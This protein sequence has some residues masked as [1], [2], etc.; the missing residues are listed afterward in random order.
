MPGRHHSVHRAGSLLGLWA[1]LLPIGLGVGVLTFAGTWFPGRPLE[2]ASMGVLFIGQGLVLAA[3]LLPRW[4][5]LIPTD[6][7]ERLVI[8]V[9][10][11]PFGTQRTWLVGEAR[12]VALVWAADC[13]PLLND[14]ISH[15]SVELRPR[16]GKACVIA[17]WPA[18]FMPHDRPP[19]ALVLLAE[20]LARRLRAPLE[21][22]LEPPPIGLMS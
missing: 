1:P 3:P 5:T 11:G 20:E 19:V 2:V 18:V 12:A 9:G 21:R 10:W 14:G 4:V 6:D 22:E 15:F 17:R 13:W 16:D 8:R 7:G